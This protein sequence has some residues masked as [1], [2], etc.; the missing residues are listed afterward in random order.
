MLSFF[1]VFNVVLLNMA[2][3]STVA[4]VLLQMDEEMRRGAGNMR[5]LYCRMGEKLFF[6]ASLY[7][8][9]E[10]DCG[11]EE[12]WPDTQSR[13]HTVTYK[14]LSFKAVHSFLHRLCLWGAG[15][16]LEKPWFGSL[17]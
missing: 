9:K 5:I 12:N 14:W 8:V 3:Q 6:G 17:D 2:C 7:E 13:V 4:V 10:C 1:S 15:Q 11:T 16:L